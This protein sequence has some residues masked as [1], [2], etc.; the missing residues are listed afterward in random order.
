MNLFPPDNLIEIYDASEVDRLFVVG[1]LHGCYQEFMSKLEQINF[2]FDRDKIISVGDLV[3]RG[4]ESFQCL[5]LVKQPWF[6]A[7]RGNHEQMCL[8]AALAPEM[9]NFHSRHGGQWLYDLS[10]DKYNDA[11]KLCL[12]LPIVLEITFKDKTYGFVHAD[13]NINDW[14]EF[15]QRLLESS[16]FS[17]NAQ[18]TLQSALWG[19]G[20]IRAAQ[21]HQDLKKVSGINQIYLGHTVVDRVT[22]VHNC[23]YLDTG[24]VFGGELTIKEIES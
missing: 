20:R 2:N 17:N 1:D 14:D 22:Q 21:N 8:E 7:I 16:Y 13:I 5:E 10:N 18:S 12:N 3:D 24:G 11:L 9:K 15:K 19:R 4:K 6:K 23:C